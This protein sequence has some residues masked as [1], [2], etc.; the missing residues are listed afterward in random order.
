[1]SS[2]PDLPRAGLDALRALVDRLGR[3]PAHADG[4]AAAPAPAP[5]KAVSTHGA[6]WARLRV[7]RRL[8]EALAQVPAQAGPLNSSQV[9]HRALRELHALAP[10]YLDALLRQVDTL[11]WLEQSAGLA[12]P[13]PGTAARGRPGGRRT[14]LA[15]AQ[16]GGD[17]ARGDS[18]A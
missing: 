17:A 5:L 1:M 7:D 9:L 2:T 10:G 11:L 6:T 12:D 14:P 18:S 8:R 16:R 15:R 13:R 3:V 4:T